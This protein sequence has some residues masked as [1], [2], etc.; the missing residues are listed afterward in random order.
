MNEYCGNKSATLADVNYKLFVKF[1][2][3]GM[4]LSS[5]DCWV[6][7]DENPLSLN[8]GFI[9]FDPAGNTVYDR[10]AVNH[11]NL[12]SFSFADGHAE[13]HK[14]FN[15][16]LSATSMSAGSDCKWLGMHGTY[17]K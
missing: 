8:D 5:S 17:H 10:P 11:G 14:W 1:T 9:Y 12:S 2:D 7:L 13:L 6:F 3:F 15:T 16:Y 4:G